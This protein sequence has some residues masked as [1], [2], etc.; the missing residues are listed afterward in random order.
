MAARGSELLSFAPRVCH[1]PKLEFS[2]SDGK[3]KVVAACLRPKVTI[4]KSSSSKGVITST[5]YGATVF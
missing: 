3:W 2:E 5:F 4:K 1:S